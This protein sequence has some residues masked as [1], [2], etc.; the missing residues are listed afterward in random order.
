VL[1]SEQKK[2]INVPYANYNDSGMFPPICLIILKTVKLPKQDCKWCT[3][4][5]STQRLPRSS[6]LVSHAVLQ[7]ARKCNLHII[8]RTYIYRW[9]KVGERTDGQGPHFGY[10]FLL[11]THW[12]NMFYFSSYFCP[13]TFR[14]DVDF[15]FLLEDTTNIY[16]S[17]SVRRPLFC[18][19]LIKTEMCRQSLVKLPIWKCMTVSS[20][21]L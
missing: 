15:A 14:C 11:R 20:S 5:Q 13:R 10:S 8:I 16:V 3:P 7:C 6:L 19:N 1:I 21:I 18:P 17:F 4:G 9:W 12:T 2:F